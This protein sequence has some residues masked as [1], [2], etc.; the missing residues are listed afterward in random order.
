M[1]VL[2]VFVLLGGLFLTIFCLFKLF[3]SPMTDFAEVRKDDLIFELESKNLALRNRNAVLVKENFL[4]K[5]AAALGL[6]YPTI[7][8][9]ENEERQINEIIEKEL[10]NGS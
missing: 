7:E 2:L 4:L 8:G 9:F 5:E 1:T 6:P 3:T 10:N